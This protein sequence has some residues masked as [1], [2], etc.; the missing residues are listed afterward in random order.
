MT[1]VPVYLDYQATTP[2]D[3]RVK[4][5]MTPYWDLHFGN[6]HS[7][8][9]YFGWEAREAVGEAR[10]AVAELI[11]TD[12]EEII[13][14]SGA[15]E[16][17]NLAIQGVARA[18]NEKRT[19]I[20]TLATEHPAV[21]ETVKYL[22]KQG[23]EPIILPVERNGLVDLTTLE[24]ALDER[25][26]LVSVMA[27]NNEIGVIQPLADIAALCQKV[28]AI[29]H[30][31]ATQAIGRMPVNVDDLG[32]D[33]LSMS[34]HKIYG[35]KGVG[36]LFIRNRSGLSLEPLIIG[37][38]QER[39]VRAGTVPVPLVVGLGTTCEI[40]G[41]EQQSDIEHLQRLTNLLH[42]RLLETYPE[43]LVFGDMEHRVPGNLNIGF[44]GLMAEELIANVT[45]KIA[46]STGAACSSATFEPS[47]VLLELGL[48]PEIA[49]TSVRLSLGRF[50]TDEDIDV[51]CA[52]FMCSAASANASKAKKDRM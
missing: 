23:F 17:C 28:G 41:T 1:S 26:L 15:T 31:D 22:R 19:R 13:F 12:D 8:N 34:G 45:D 43:M 42:N 7:R 48:K 37:G 3:P 16:S 5:A 51:A 10:A 21:L 29:F 25:V 36:I 46:I 33:M 50:S 18:A 4:E 11:G 2:L 39:G 52:A 44:P 47:K 30:S 6:P 32:V 38:G 24:Q 35:P 20:I 9:H 40:I 14:T 49:A 27:A